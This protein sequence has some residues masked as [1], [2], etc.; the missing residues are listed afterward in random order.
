MLDKLRRIF[1]K[2]SKGIMTNFTV[3]KKPRFFQYLVFGLL[4]GN[5][6]YSIRLHFIIL[7]FMTFII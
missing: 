1:P 2:V 3:E 5:C 4:R 7:I 6:D